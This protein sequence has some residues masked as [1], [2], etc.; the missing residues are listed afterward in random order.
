MGGG[1][2]LNRGKGGSLSGGSRLKMPYFSGLEW[3]YENFMAK[4]HITG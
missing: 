1:E 3:G 4:L 2:G